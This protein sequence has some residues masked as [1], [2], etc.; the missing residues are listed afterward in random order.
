MRRRRFVRSKRRPYTW[1]EHSLLAWALYC[2][3]VDLVDISVATHNRYG[4]SNTLA[5]ATRRAE[6]A[7]SRLRS[8]LDSQLF[9]DHPDTATADVYYPGIEVE[10]EFQDLDEPMP[11]EPTGGSKWHAIGI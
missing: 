7:I 11:S 5:A 4:K 2:T 8:E 6:Q 1:D 3:Y 9:K 10:R